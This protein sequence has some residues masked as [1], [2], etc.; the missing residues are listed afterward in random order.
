MLGNSLRFS[1]SLGVA[2][3]VAGLFGCTSVPRWDQDAPDALTVEHYGLVMA[4]IDVKS[5]PDAQAAF[6][7]LRDDVLRVRTNNLAVQASL[8]QLYRAGNQVDR[9][10]WAASR[11]ITLALK[12]DYASEFS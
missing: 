6:Y 12:R 3:L 1:V 7:L 5:K 10:D 4:A 8:A 2:I 9:E 11:D